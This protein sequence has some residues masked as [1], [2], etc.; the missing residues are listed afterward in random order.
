MLAGTKPPQSLCSTMV[1]SKPAADLISKRRLTQCHCQ[2][3]FTHSCHKAPVRMNLQRS[4]HKAFNPS[5]RS[6]WYTTFHQSS[7]NGLHNVCDWLT[8]RAN[9]PSPL[10][11]W[12]IT[13]NY[14]Y[15]EPMAVRKPDQTVGT[16]WVISYHIISGPD[17]EQAFSVITDHITTCSVTRS[18]HLR[19]LPIRSSQKCLTFFTVRAFSVIF[20]GDVGEPI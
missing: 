18:F 5:S 16:L 11:N 10:H 4:L 19:L 2:F 3:S 15:T 12:Y 20:D 9:P 1:A 8:H 17:P 13:K 6:G 14:T 7:S